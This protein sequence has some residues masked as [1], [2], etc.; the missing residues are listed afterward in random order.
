MIK[1]LLL[2]LFSIIITVIMFE[3]TVFLFFN[4]EY[5]AFYI[6][7]KNMYISDLES[8][9]HLLNPSYKGIFYFKDSNHPVNINKVGC[10]DYEPHSS[11]INSLFLGDSY[12]WGY[13]DQ[14]SRYS[15]LYGGILSLD[16]LNCAIAGSGPK[17]QLK[18][19]NKLY[20]K[21]YRFDKVF[22]GYFSN[23]F[24]DDMLFPRYRVRNGYLEANKIIDDNGNII[25]T[26]YDKQLS[27]D[28]KLFI[29]THSFL[30]RMVYRFKQSNKFKNH[31]Q[32]SDYKL[33]KNV[34][35]TSLEYWFNK[36][37][38]NDMF[39]KHLEEI[40]K[41]KS[42]VEENNG[43]FVL[44]NIPLW[45]ELVYEKPYLQKTYDMIKLFCKEKN[46]D[47]VSNFKLTRDYYWFEDGHL[48]HKGHKVIAEKLSSIYK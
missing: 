39:Y 17:S 1:N 23:D 4:D 12:T 37:N 30:A 44:V 25:T 18:I 20:D 16:V 45:E 5:Y 15:D 2:S 7:Q 32:K 19:L 47:L 41:M 24:I 11:K 14:Q 28:L 46:I 21:N 33:S 35:K 27:K 34:I 3:L 36:E 9:Q 38:F 31:N 48:N 22:Y 13:I 6:P 26:G 10:F 40:Y 29:Y 8:G 42:I 43:K